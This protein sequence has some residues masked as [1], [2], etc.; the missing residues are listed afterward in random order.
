MKIIA[1]LGRAQWSDTIYVSLN[2]T[3]GTKPKHFHNKEHNVVPGVLS[4]S[5]FDTLYSKWFSM[6]EF[7]STGSV[8]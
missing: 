6:Y 4:D 8:A 1:P 5:Y 3:K 7:S 2:T